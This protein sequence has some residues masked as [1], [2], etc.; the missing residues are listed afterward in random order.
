MAKLLDRISNSLNKTGLD[1]RTKQSR[2]WLKQN[3]NKLSVDPKTLVR[4]KDR[5][6]KKILPGKMYFF[7]YDPKLKEVL[8]YYDRFPLVM[9]I[10]K[11]NDG[12]LG[13]NFHY[14]PIQYRIVLLDK[15]YDLVNNDKFNE[16]TKL[17]VSYNILNGSSRFKEFAPC[18]KRY[19]TQ[20]IQSPMIEVESDKWETAIFLP[21]EKFV[22]EKISKIH[23]NSQ[24]LI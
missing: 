22:G 11:Y 5:F 16:T 1:L 19:L 3:V 21:V 2:T 8:P 23:K 13:L 10:E 17:Q 20:H 14:L 9:P 18:V 4:D 6:A 24:E 12:F 15:L 7:F